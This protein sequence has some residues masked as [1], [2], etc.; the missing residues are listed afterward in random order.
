MRWHRPDEPVFVRH[1]QSS[2]AEI[3]RRKKMERVVDRMMRNPEELVREM[4]RIVEGL[5]R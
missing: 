2:P 4:K 3:A 1:D 5:K